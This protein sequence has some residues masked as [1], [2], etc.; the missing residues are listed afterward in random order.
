MDARRHRWRLPRPVY[1]SRGFAH[2]F[3]ALGVGHQRRGLAV[4]QGTAG[5]NARAIA[6]AETLSGISVMSTASYCPNAK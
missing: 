2:R 5:A 3:Q 4:A 6:A 1:R